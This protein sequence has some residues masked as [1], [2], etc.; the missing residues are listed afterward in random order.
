[1]RFDSLVFP[2]ISSFERAIYTDAWFADATFTGPAGFQSATFLS[3]TAFCWAKFRERASFNGVKVERAFDMT[4]AEFSHVPAFNQAL[5]Q[6]PDL[7]DVRLP[8]P[9]PWR[10]SR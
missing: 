6:A 5:Q 2:G 10:K 3:S 8:L 9:S 4:G 7:D 1:L